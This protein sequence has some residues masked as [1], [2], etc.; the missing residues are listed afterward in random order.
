MLCVLSFSLWQLLNALSLKA[1]TSSRLPLVHCPVTRLE[2]GKRKE[3]SFQC[4]ILKP[5]TSALLH[6]DHMYS[7]NASAQNTVTRCNSF[8]VETHGSGSFNI[9]NLRPFKGARMFFKNSNWNIIWLDE[10]Y[11]HIISCFPS[12]YAAN[13]Q[14]VLECYTCSLVTHKRKKFK[15]TH[16]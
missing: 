15:K 9:L 2:G 13:F 1:K 3:F 6:P 10:S 8:R 12:L 7:P 5:Q 16:F 11:C 14:S 4:G